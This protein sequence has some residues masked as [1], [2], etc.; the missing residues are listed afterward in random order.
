MN[1]ARE[2]L[3]YWND[4][5]S[6]ER[7]RVRIVLTA[8]R[9]VLSDAG[10]GH[11]V[12]L[13]P[14]QGLSLAEE[15]YRGQPLRFRHAERGD[16]RLSVEE[17]GLLDAL[18]E[19]QPGLGRRYL[20]RRGA[21]SRLLLW[22][23]GAA[24]L[25]LG[26]LFGL[27]RL[28]GPLAQLVPVAWEDSLGRELVDQLAGGVRC[29]APE[30]LQALA[31]LR[32]RLQGATPGPYRYRVQVVPGE[33]VNALA[34]P[35]G[36]ILIYDGLLQAVEGPEE[37]TAVLAHE[38]AHVTHRHGTQALIRQAGY[39]LLL[40][41]MLGDAS[42]AASVLTESGVMLLGLAHSRAAEAEAD[43]AAIARLNA[44]GLDSRGLQRFFAR[45][46]AEG[47]ELPDSLALLSS[48]PLHAERVEQAARLSRAGEAPLDGHQ[49]RALKGICA[50]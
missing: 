29:E 33:M 28:A 14:L 46:K 6:A 5:Y 11:A 15:V 42:A 21:G 20:G 9:L 13:L 3:G 37:L 26:L 41:A 7:Q 23:G 47:D 12:T 34:A 22:G 17:H 36:H 25:A 45:L 50:P 48:H 40:T 1:Q 44:A 8:D 35:G 30:G 16:A 24:L 43:R 32:R 27:P 18:R 39:S 4:G 49:W 2:W 19:R 38:M 10:N 31:V